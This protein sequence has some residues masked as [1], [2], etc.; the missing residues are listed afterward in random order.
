MRGPRRIGLL[1]ISGVC[2]F[3]FMATSAFAADELLT[4]ENGGTRLRELTTTPA[5]SPDSLEFVNSG[6]LAWKLSELSNTCTEIELGA[7]VKTNPVG[8]NPELAL[9]WGVAEGDNCTFAVLFGPVTAD[10]AHPG[11]L[12]TSMVI[13]DDEPRPNPIHA[14]VTK[15]EMA[16]LGMPFGTCIYGVKEAEKL[17]GNVT[18][19][20]GPY[21][22]E[23]AAPNLTVSFS[24]KTMKKQAGS[25]EACPAEIELTKA[26]FV[27]ETPST[28]TDGAFYS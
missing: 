13:K 26:V 2:L 11:A 16:W 17:V 27:L 9:P 22:E 6:S 19:T 8:G 12:Q 20:G 4:T 21:G 3:A 18:T 10:A 1:A 7:F 25:G 28:N 5:G 24:G 15:F 14:E 23:G